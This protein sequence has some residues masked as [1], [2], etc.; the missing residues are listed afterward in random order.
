MSIVDDLKGVSRLQIHAQLAPSQG[1]RFQPTGFPDLGAAEY[2]GPNGE[3]ELLVESAQ[4]MANRLETVCWDDVADNWVEPLRGLPFIRVMNQNG[5]SFTNSILESHRINSSYIIDAPDKKIYQMIKETC[6]AELGPVNLRKFAKLLLQVDPNT[7][8]HGVF[9]SRKDLSGGR[10]R[11]PRI[12]SSFIE[13]H[14]VNEAHSGG[15]KNDQVNP[16]GNTAAGYGNVP[17][18]R[19]EYTAREIVAYFSLDLAQLRALNL[20]ADAEHLLIS[21]AIYKIQRLLKGG[22]RLRTACDLDV[23]HTEVIRPEGIQLPSLEE[24]ERGLPDLITTL[25]K[26]GV[27]GDEIQ[28]QFPLKS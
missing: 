15:V 17:F 25:K 6:G 13:A 3:S 5:E 27:L 18:H 4:S 21:L 28:V 8:L 26:A 2:V 7:L 9:V 23:H 22:L 24:L 10:L 19:I 11:L 1:T 16:S 14:G 20:G 12:L